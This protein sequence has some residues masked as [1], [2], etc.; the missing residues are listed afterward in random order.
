MRAVMQC[1][2]QGYVVQGP[3][4]TLLHLHEASEHISGGSI[5]AEG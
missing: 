1:Q 4:G 3:L 5:H 2:V